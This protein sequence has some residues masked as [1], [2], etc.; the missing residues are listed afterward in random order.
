MRPRLATAVVAAISLMSCAANAAVTVSFEAV[1]NDPLMFSG[2]FTVTLPWFAAENTRIT[3]DFTASC[4]VSVG[5]HGPC[6]EIYLI[7]DTAPLFNDNRGDVLDAVAIGPS[8]GTVSFYYFANG[9]LSAPGTHHNALEWPPVV[10]TLALSG[11]AD[12]PQPAQPPIDFFPTSDDGP[13]G[14]VPEPAT[15]ALMIGGF[16]LAGAMLRRRHPKFSPP[17]TV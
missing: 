17:P 14:G 1:P 5:V 7:P 2:S 6:A 10:T 3:S 13:I 15:W 9:A 12:S 8:P 4:T 11:F 16:G